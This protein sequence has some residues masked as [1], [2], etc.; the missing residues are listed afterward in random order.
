MTV[1]LARHGE[2][3]NPDRVVYAD[4]PGFGLS[5]RGRAEAAAAAE[6][7]A[8]MGAEAIYASPLQR[9]QETAAIIGAAVSWARCN[10][11]A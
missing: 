11:E 5:D 3:D 9:A 10:G 8:R 7:L 1:Y 2:V 4:M 6:H